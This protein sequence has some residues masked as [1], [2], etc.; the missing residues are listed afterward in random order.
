MNNLWGLSGLWG[1]KG[2]I[3]LKEAQKQLHILDWVISKGGDRWRGTQR[4]GRSKVCGVARLRCG[5]GAVFHNMGQKT[6]DDILFRSNHVQ[7]VQTEF[8]PKEVR[9]EGR[10]VGCRGFIPVDE[11][12]CDLGGVGGKGKFYSFEKLRISCRLRQMR[13]GSRLKSEGEGTV[14]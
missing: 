3:L 2:R 12:H 6:V 5:R 4:F 11:R 13:G 9:G 7:L 14:S 10:K 1:H 8:F